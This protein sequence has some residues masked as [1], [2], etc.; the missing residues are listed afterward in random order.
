M[1][2]LLAL[3]AAA[4]YGTADFFGG[5]GAC[6]AAALSVTA[7]AQGIGVVTV[8]LAL[9]FFPPRCRPGTASSGAQGPG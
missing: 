5:L 8:A 9:P 1:P 7:L 2:L 6:R 4:F 3:L